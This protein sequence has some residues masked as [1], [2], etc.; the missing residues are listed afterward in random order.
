MYYN[1]SSGEGWAK[2]DLS[3]YMGKAAAKAP[4]FVEAFFDACGDLSAKGMAVPG[5]D[6][7][8]LILQNHDS[9][10]RVRPPKLEVIDLVGELIQIPAVVPTQAQGAADVLRGCGERSQSLLD[11]GRGREAV[12][13]MLWLLETVST[14]FKGLPTS[15]GRV[16]GTY[17]NRIVGELKV[18]ANRP[19][20]RRVLDWMVSMHGFLS[21]PSGGGVRHGLD[22]NDGVEIND[23]EALLFCNLIRSY[24]GFLL[25]EY[26]RLAAASEVLELP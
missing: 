24:L 12:Q 15:S 7:I 25:S 22:L 20:I 21:A 10:L 13:Q 5:P 1:R 14:G 6:E 26:D 8:N 19:T 18:K 4:Q 3:D 17:F 2:S 23:I 16:E 11:E 9:P